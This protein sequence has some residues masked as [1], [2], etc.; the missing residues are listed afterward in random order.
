MNT[1]FTFPPNEG[2][3][4][5]GG[6]KFPP[7]ADDAAEE[8]SAGDES[9]IPDPYVE[10]QA[11]SDDK[12]A[13]TES[14]DPAQPT[15]T[16]PGIIRAS[17]PLIAE[18]IDEPTGLASSEV[19]V[20]QAPINA[21]ST[22]KSFVNEYAE[23]M[24][25]HL[26]TDWKSPSEYALHILF[27]KFVRHAG[28]KL[29]LCLQY[30]LDSEP[31]IVDLLGEGVDQA[32]D[33]IIESLGYIS[34]NKPKPVIDAMMFWRKTK[35]EVAAVAAENV[36]KL[37]QEYDHI[38]QSFAIQES[39]KSPHSGTPT[40]RTHAKS[41]SSSSKFSHKRNN[42]SKSY[43]S[44][45]S[46]AELRLRVVEDQIEAAK[47]TAFQADRKSLISIYILCRVLIEIV[48]QGPDSSDDDLH[49]KLEEIV[50]TQLKT[51][52]P[53]SISSSII[54]SSNWNSFAELLG[55]MSETKFVAVSDRFIADLEKMPSLLPRELEPSVHLLI[56]GMRYLRLKNYPLEQFEESADF[57]KSLAKFFAT[58]QNHSI[59][60]AYAEVISQLLLPLAGSLTAEVN[61]PTWVEA[62]A[63]IL[64]TCKKFQTDNKFWSSSFK[65]TVTILCVSP[66]ELF[67]EHWMPLLENN[68]IKVKSKSLDERVVFATGLSRLMWVYLFRCTETLNNTE[69][70]LKKLFSLFLSTKKKDNW[71]TTD[72][73][74][75]NPLTDM[76]VTIG[77]LHPVFI[78]ENIIIP[79]TR[80]SFNGSTLENLSFE[81]LIL[82]IDSYRGLLVSSER[83]EFPEND[84]RFYELNLNKVSGK[85]GNAVASDHEEV[86]KTFY[87]LFL[88]LDSSI[89]SEVWSPENEHQRQ[90][91][92]PFSGISSFNFKFSN[93]NSSN[94]N[95]SLNAA[96]FAALIEAMPCCLTVSSSIPFKSTIEILA[97]N[98]V[99]RNLLVASSSQSALKAL[100]LKKNPY[101]LITWFAKYSFDFD[102][103]TQS[104][105][106]MAYLS[107]LEYRKL[108]VLYIELLQCWLSEFKAD[109][110]KKAAAETSLGGHG[111]SIID[112]EGTDTKDTEKYEWKNIATVIEDVEGNGLFFLCS[113]DHT[114][115][116]LAI[117]ILRIVSKF[118]E[119]MLEKTHGLE[120][121]HARSSSRFV[122]ES[123]TRLIDLLQSYNYSNLLESRKVTISVAEKAR[124]GKLNAK[125]K[126]G[127]LIKLAESD[128]GVD[129]ALWMRAFPKLLTLVF[130]QSPMTMALCRSIV[131]IR[132]VQLHEIVLS[133]ASNTLSTP[134][135]V[136]PEVIVNQWKLYLIVACSSLT[137]TTD[138]KLHIPTTNYQH[139]RNKSQQI[140]TVQHQKIKS[141]TSIFKMVL[142]LLNCENSFVK[143]AI[144]TGLSSMNVNIFKAY[145]Q[146]VDRFLGSWRVGSSSNGMRV[147]MFHILAVLAPFFTHE[148]IIEDEWILRKVSQYL[149]DAKKFLEEKEVQTSFNYQQ[150]RSYF[151][152][153][154]SSFY[155]AVKNLPLVEDLFP[156]E[157]RASCFNF[158][159]E[160]CGYGQ[161]SSMSNGRYNEMRKKDEFRHNGTLSTAIEFQK[162][163][164]EL[165]TLETMANLCCDTITKKINDVPGSPIIISFDISGLICWIDSLF[166]AQDERVCKLGTVA[167]KGLLENNKENAQLY[168][169]TLMQYSLHNLDTRV[170][171]LYYTAVC[172]SLLE[173]ET[174]ILP[175]DDVV[176]LGLSGIYNE[177]S[178]VRSYS[179]DLLSA[180]ETKIY[181]SSYTKV[182]K[183]R[184][185]NDSKTVYKST[186]KEI[187]TIFAEIPSTEVRLKIFSIMCRSIN[188]LKSELKQDI[189]TLLVPWVHKFTLKSIEDGGTFMILNNLFAMTVEHN[190]RYPMEIEQLWIS[191]G[192]GN[193]FQNIHVALDYTLITSTSSRNP[194][195]VK[196]AKDV[197]LYLAN[198]PGGMGVIDSFMIN[199]EPKH[200]IPETA[201]SKKNPAVE[202]KY[203][204]VANVWKLLGYRGR[205]VV[206]SKAQLS[207]VFLVNLLTIPNESM[208]TK[209]P[210]LLHICFS[211]LDHYV[212]IIQ[213]SAAKILSDLIFG[214]APTHEESEETVAMIKDRTQIWSYDNLM[215]DKNGARS[216]K[217][218]DSLI[219]NVVSLFS[220]FEA[221][222]RDWQNIA[223][224]W[225]TSCPVRHIAC[226][227]FQI[228]RSLLTFLD[229]QMLRD[230]LHRL[231]NTIS[232]ENPEIQGFAMQILMTLNAV[233]AELSAAKLIDFPQM[234]WA[235]VA[236]LNSVHE[237]EFI[238]VLSSL[239]KFVS[240]IDLDS[241][242]TV[243]C[244]IATFPSSWEGKFDGLQQTIMCGL[245]SSNSW[246]IAL[247]FLDRLNLFKDSRIIANSES[248][249]LFALLANLP[250]FLNAM[251]TDEF[252]DHLKKAADSLI[253]L[254]TS[255]NQ[256]SL[257]RL[258]DSLA[259]KKF[260]SKKDFVSQTVS[261]ISRVYFPDYSAQTLVFLLGLLFNKID[262]VRTQ[263]LQLLVHIVPLIDLRRPE[264]VGVGADLISPVLRLL[265]TEYESQA[266]EL[267]NC[268]RNVSGSKMDKDVLRISMGNKDAKIAY[269]RTATLFGI[270][271]ESG[272]SVPM[273]TVTAATTRH[274]VHAVFSTCSDNSSDDPIQ[275]EP[276]T[277]KDLVE[278]HADGGYAAAAAIEA[279]DTNSL[280]EDKDGSLSH[281]WA[282]LDNLDTFFTTEAGITEPDFDGKFLKHAH[283]N[284][285]DTMHA[286]QNSAL[287]CAPQLYD[288]KVSVILNHS[289]TRTPS[290]VSFKTN[291]ADSFGNSM[292]GGPHVMVENLS[293]HSRANSGP[294]RSSSAGNYSGGK[295]HSK[296]AQTAT[297]HSLET[298]SPARLRNPENQELL[299]RFEGILRNPHRTKKKW[300]K[301]QHQ[302]Q[303]L[304]A[305][306]FHDESVNYH[307][308]RDSA[309]S[310]PQGLGTK[311]SPPLSPTLSDSN[312]NIPTAL[313]EGTKNK[314][315]QPKPKTQKHHYHIPHF[316]SRL[317]DGKLTPPL[318]S[319]SNA[320][321]LRSSPSPR[322]SKASNSSAPASSQSQF[323]RRVKSGQG[324]SKSGNGVIETSP[325]NQ[326]T[327]VQKLM[328]D[329]NLEDD[330]LIE[331]QLLSLQD[332]LQNRSTSNEPSS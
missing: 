113:H 273:P 14:N 247:G 48:R 236:C 92:T 237:Q 306:S 119:A 152:S 212:P 37:L 240:K 168:K 158:L 308:E 280:V 274:N 270:P 41:G 220:D 102:E 246:D 161:Y 169:D 313:R 95:R 315:Y 150:L 309:T 47:E 288:K 261:F 159:K 129:A 91:T 12:N 56:L 292:H 329:R 57:I 29:N 19:N 194:T 330:L 260:R 232:D 301:Q 276:D 147:E 61:H 139:G 81:K 331:K 22:S 314:G 151:A 67:S 224:K 97:R 137:S 42:S 2:E 146:S 27:T 255:N 202:D 112:N 63:L 190:N 209:V 8:P 316:S 17:T 111:P 13:V 166:V 210:L 49:E 125:Y 53:I 241:P 184:L 213:E 101:T 88:L 323:S 21:A 229:K 15:E 126:N 326:G 179:I 203:A 321:S 264:F 65:L 78:V 77:S 275:R 200:M 186:A 58:S 253:V 149:K 96:L 177:S 167:L 24:R 142:P 205:E 303:Q 165:I 228:F 140:F 174:F 291:L 181:K 216:P 295:S 163:R 109:A 38:K 176:S 307:F 18:Q 197:V 294:I 245:R 94:N 80:A 122:A 73:D 4:K 312:K 62:M 90:P 83:P 7:S 278:F 267:L 162:S 23:N 219:R 284:S 60:L 293:S 127:I 327:P 322:S 10:Q 207:I 195:F 201:P 114:I 217:A 124:L 269:S 52:D 204:Y 311:G 199:L 116:R 46:A 117:Q 144:I 160:W 9:A 175:E 193:G 1:G 254:A 257:A 243:Q 45:N 138:Q 93:D 157:A 277:L 300:Q 70:R 121:N 208:L 103:K 268:I 187:S 76:L 225:A 32:F 75:I 302:Q 132:L 230:M 39:A 173:M 318:S 86:C 185:A 320:F 282:E 170:A 155:L 259:K 89:G 180:I 324:K 40:H 227:S 118:D 143:D 198:V 183:E 110:E 279:N 305:Q 271:E 310:L 266:L 79:L 221:L 249:I 108:L 196:R 298:V 250:R 104:S 148:T 211:L 25:Q 44:S 214:L 287:D 206:F 145:L 136:S 285:E 242:D 30:P 272:W 299:F 54:K 304:L 85:M 98:A 319:S 123:G 36:E 251:D 283:T 233:T 6:F 115:R 72:M 100:A 154:L 244:L 189:L 238:E 218:M 290:N 153:L 235:L 297:H 223:L 59:R 231:S 120:K 68:I 192:K 33:Q 239:T 265:L 252:D 28:S 107:S 66:Q 263:T 141:A 296:V 332:E 289:L 34:K 16:S 55:C 106:N 64:D 222:Q 328:Q 69:R 156:F 191:L 35:S 172:A 43:A 135:E 256:P 51:T 286:D 281:M 188:Y 5:I 258:V 84:C 234:F 11:Q 317:S 133:I 164:L 20:T 82:A 134:K 128:Y 215:K 325:L 26:A 3:S 262:W 226:R 105:Y 31:P 99:H 131:C 71:I 130:D 74:L 248:R 171:T 87:H 50:F 178:E 182:F